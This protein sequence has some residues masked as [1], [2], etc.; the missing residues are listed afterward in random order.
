MV[1]NHPANPR[2]S[3]PKK[4]QLQDRDFV[5]LRHICRYKM[6]V[7]Q[8]L[9]RLPV[10]VG[11]SRDAVKN[12]IRRL[13]QGGWIRSAWLYDSYPVGDSPQQT[14]LRYSYYYLSESAA[15]LLGEHPGIARP[16][17][18]EPKIRAYAALAF[19]CLDEPR[20]EKLTAEEF[21]EVFPELYR[22][23]ERISYYIDTEGPQKRLGY[24]RVDYGG[25][26]RWD[27]LI[28]K[29]RSDIRKRCDNRAFRELVL[30][31]GFVITVITA[32]EQKAAR[33]RDALEDAQLPA[34]VKVH[35]VPE[36]LE[37]I[38]PGPR[39]PRNA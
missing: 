35:V 16:L 25:R 20:R 7:L 6:T 5:I 29:C 22:L 34:E 12:V 38:A 3:S 10:F 9:E 37:M 32:L 33:L 28:A 24:I 39:R 26:G 21:K 31:G 23:G 27:R 2:S 18:D 13:R 1:D 11:S 36:L 14:P 4:V 8:A 15:N 17:K 30:R 19:C